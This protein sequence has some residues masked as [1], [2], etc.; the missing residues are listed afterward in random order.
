MTISPWRLLAAFVF[1]ALAGAS[2]TIGAEEFGDIGKWVSGVCVIGAMFVLIR[3]VK[4]RGSDVSTESATPPETGSNTG[5]EKIS[6][7]RSSSLAAEAI[8][9]EEEERVGGAPYESLLSVGMRALQLNEFENAANCFYNASAVAEGAVGPTHADTLKCLGGLARALEG[10]ERFAEATP[11][12][13]RIYETQQKVL[14]ENAAETLM[15]G[16]NLALALKRD[17]KFQEAERIFF[18]VLARQETVLGV[19]HEH[20]GVTAENL[21]G[22]YK[23]VRKW[24]AAEPLYVRRFKDALRAFPAT[25]PEVSLAAMN[26]GEALLRC[27]KWEDAMPLLEQAVKGFRDS[28]GNEH[29]GT[30]Q[31]TVLLE[32][33]ERAAAMA[34]ELIAY[35]DVGSE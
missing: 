4:A 30:R 12:Y 26:L 17:G 19:E 25:H 5:S 32:E 20:T 23:E 31:A 8:N 28:F 10:M 35:R 24:A 6:Q 16:N 34:K 11:V 14:G 1:L 27:G 21:A 3:G 13:L 33:S 15:S 7:P 18:Q 9:Q 29:L 2:F 22:L